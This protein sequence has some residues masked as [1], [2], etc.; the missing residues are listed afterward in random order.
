[1]KYLT[2]FFY[3]HIGRNVEYYNWFFVNIILHP[4]TVY[5]T[6]K[7][8]HGL[9]QQWHRRDHAITKIVFFFN[10]VLSTIFAFTFVKGLWK[11]PYILFDFAI[12]LVTGVIISVIIFYLCKS[13]FTTGDS[14]T[15]RY[16]YDIHINAYFCY[17]LVSHILLF[18]LSPFLFRDSLWATFASNGV[19]LVSLAYYT[20]ITFLGYNI[21]PFMK[22]PKT[23]A[24]A[25][26]A[27]FSLL[28]V[29][30]SALGINVPLVLI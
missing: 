11:V 26:I 13:S 20:Y 2:Q 19:L 24:Y 29:F 27:V 9:T 4:Q 18:V 3:K 22:I 6:N 7:Y 30:F 10:F 14:F 12:P 16:S 1:M 25:P 8:Q 21:L 15:V 5:E 17:L 28:L 23:A